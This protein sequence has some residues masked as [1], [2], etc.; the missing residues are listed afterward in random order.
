LFHSDVQVGQKSKPDLF[1]RPI[2]LWCS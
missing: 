2:L 1:Y